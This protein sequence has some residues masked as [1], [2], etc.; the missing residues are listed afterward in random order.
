MPRSD[1]TS[2]TPVF[3]LCLFYVRIATFISQKFSRSS[4]STWE[5]GGL[6]TCPSLQSWRAAE[7][8]FEPTSVY[9]PTALLLLPD[10]TAS[11]HYIVRYY[12]LL[13]RHSA[14]SKDLIPALKTNVSWNQYWVQFPSE[15]KGKLWAGIGLFWRIHFCPF[16][17]LKH[18]GTSLT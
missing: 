11:K 6:V 13:L 3:M 12:V 8:R 4:L 16:W 9:S 2:G 7:A 5:N 15:V 1:P 18:L 10:N 14:S 17:S